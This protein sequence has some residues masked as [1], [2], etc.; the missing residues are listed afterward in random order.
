LV[1]ELVGPIR[2]AQRA[3]A[4]HIARI[5]DEVVA[6]GDIDHQ[7]ILAHKVST[8]N[9]EVCPAMAITGGKRLDTAG[10][11]GSPENPHERA[12]HM[13]VSTIPV[14][15]VV[16]AAVDVIAVM[17]IALASAWF[18]GDRSQGRI[19]SVPKELTEEGNIVRLSEGLRVASAAA[20][21]ARIGEPGL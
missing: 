21:L 4:L 10:V 14:P 19:V 6:H 5:S 12:Q 13:L 15:A 16:V 9:V 11:A 7:I 2:V 20:K 8:H 3:V 1:K 18:L 17:T